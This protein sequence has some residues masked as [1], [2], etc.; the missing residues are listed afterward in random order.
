MK[1]LSIILGLLFIFT[2]SGFAQITRKGGD[3]RPPVTI[4]WMS[5]EEAMQKSAAAP[6]KIIVDVYTS[7]CKWCDKMEETTFRDPVIAQYIN[8]NF[9]AV[10]FDAELQQEIN[11]KDKSY[12]N[13]KN[14][15]RGYHDLIK[16]L[17]GGRFSF[18]TLIFLDEN[19]N[20]IQCV[21]GFKTPSQFEQISSYFADNH[22]RKIPWSSFQEMYRQLDIKE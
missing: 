20:L 14:G 11:Y 1:K 4:N 16:E 10:K 2:I 12:G 6:K 19:Q 7:W 3:V 8:E 18:P 13:S 22:Y 17:T 5:L 21:V 15:K 9:Y